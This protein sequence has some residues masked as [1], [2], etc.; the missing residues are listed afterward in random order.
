ME[1]SI[2]AYFF[3]AGP[4]VKFVMLL[5]LMASVISWA[6]IFQRAQFMRGLKRSLRNFESDVWSSPDFDQLFS[7][8]KLASEKPSGTQRLFYAG[9]KEFKKLTHHKDVNESMVVESVQR[10]MRIAQAQEADKLE[11]H[12]SFLATVGSISPYVGLLGTVWGIMTAF[13]ALGQAQQVTVAM[14]APGIAEALV[15]TAMGLFAAI[16]AVIAYNKYRQ[17]ADSILDE[18]DMFQEQL[19]IALQRQLSSERVQDSLYQED[20]E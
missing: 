1:Q 10:A 20:E 6:F 16:P 11:K 17:D 4:V 3:A 14:V 13:Q 18:Y 9:F 12:L 2:F 15:A 19:T 5:L 8:L 7:R